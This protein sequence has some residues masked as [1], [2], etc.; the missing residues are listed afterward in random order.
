[1][2]YNSVIGVDRKSCNMAHHVRGELGGELATVG[3]FRKYRWGSFWVSISGVLANYLLAFIAYPL[4][5][6]ALLYVPQFGK[7]TEV[8]VYALLFVYL[9]SLS[10]TVFNLLPIYPLDGFRVVDSFNKKR[11]KIYRFLRNYGIY[12]LYALFFLSII[13]DA[14]N[15]PALDILGFVINNVVDFI[16]K[17]ITLFWGLIL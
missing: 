17:P 15:K 4:Y 12:I 8:L 9:M 6:L 11:G 2:H 7:F 3:N 14:M 1:M 16:S 10:F 13:S 5:I